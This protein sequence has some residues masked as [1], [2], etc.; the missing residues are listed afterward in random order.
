V[1]YG[2]VLFYST[3]LAI[4]AERVCQRAGFEVKLIPT[5]RQLSSDCGTALRFS[6]ADVD[7][8]QAALVGQGVEV[9]GLHAI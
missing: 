7:R 2:V 4:R 5:P 3:S 9:E 6:W 8:V 1:K